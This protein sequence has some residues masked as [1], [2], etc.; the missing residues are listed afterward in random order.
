MKID[1]SQVRE[2]REKTGAGIM[3]CKNALMESQG[4]MGAAVE[5]LRRK[6]AA[7]AQKKSSRS[8][9]E[10]I[11]ASYVHSNNKVATLVELNCETDFVAR[12]EEFAELGKDLCM[13]VAAMNPIAVSRDDLP[14]DLVE[15]EREIYR[16]QIK[17]KPDHIVEKIVEGRLKKFYEQACLLEQPFIKDDKSKVEDLLTAKIAKLGENIRVRRF[18]RLAVGESTD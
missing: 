17:D 13:Q 2:L 3:D 5:W 9:A 12:N 16:A 18:C 4:D 15:K 11:I 14:E 6:G 1:A 7:T 10:G 8:T